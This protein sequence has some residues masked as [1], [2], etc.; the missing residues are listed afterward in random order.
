MPVVLFNDSLCPAGYYCPRGTSFAYE[1]P[2]PPGTFSNISGLSSVEG[3]TPCLPGNYCGESGLIEPSGSCFAGYFCVAGSDTP[4]PQESQCPAG[5][6]CPIGTHTPVPCPTGTFSADTLN[7]AEEDCML[8]G[9]GH[10]CTREGAINATNMPCSDGYVCVG[11]AFTPTPIDNVT[12]YA[13]PAGHFCTNASFL[14]QKCP[15]GSYQ[16]DVGKAQCLTCPIGTICYTS[17]LVMYELCPEGYYCPDM[18]MINGIPCP[19]GTFSNITGNTNISDCISCPVG[20]Y[21]NSLSLTKP[22]GFCEAGYLCVSS[23]TSPSPQDGLNEPCPPGFY[24]Q[25]GATF[26]E[27]CPTG[28]MAPYIDFSLNGIDLAQALLQWFANSSYFVISPAVGLGSVEDCLP[29]IGGFYCQLLNSTL[30]TGPCQAGYY[31]PHNASVAQG[32]PDMYQCPLG[33]YCPMASSAPIECPPGTYANTTMTITCSECPVGHF[34][35]VGAVIPTVCPPRYYCPAGSSEPLFCP[36]GTYTLNT[37]YGLISED[38]CV[39]C[40][41][42][43]FCLAG[44]IVGVCSAGYICYQGSGD[45]TPDGS[46]PTVGEPCPEGFYCIQGASS[47]TACSEGL[48]NV[49]PGGRSPDDC[50]VCPPGRVCRNGSRLAEMCP[51]GFFC[52]NGT[53]ISC[54]PGTYSLELN[55]E[56]VSFC[57]PCEPGFLCPDEATAA[58]DQ[59]PCPVGHYCDRGSSYPTACPPGTHRNET[60]GMNVTDCIICPAG[61]YCSENGTVHGVPCDISESCPEG[62]IDPIPCQPGFYC[63]VPEI[64]LPCPPGYYCPEGSSTFIECPPDHYCEQPACERAF[65]EQA[66]ADRPSICP[67]GYREILNLGENFTRDSLNATCEECPPGTYINASSLTEERI[68]LP[69]PPGYYCIGGSTFGD[70]GTSPMLFAFICPLGHY[71]PTGSEEPVACPV[72]TYNAYEGQSSLSDCT[73]CAMNE[74]N[75]MTGQ[76]GCL[77]CPS[78]STTFGNGSTSCDCIGSNRVFQV[79]N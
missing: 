55:A 52:M 12:G 58:Y 57:L 25:E 39:P 40:I 30:P 66:G 16:P 76:Q 27:P 6:F 67:L 21:C 77:L 79:H 42:S 8:C 4:T 10:Y 78:R 24:C 49:L 15:P 72:G 13:C 20:M 73:P 71:C 32:D 37:T 41:Q 28:T 60:T 68:C 3:C 23:A 65:T 22:S 48:F 11:G 34:C 35:S 1:Y 74:Y 44:E 46:N 36:N 33:N 7:V 61:F 56:D 19:L 63:P 51:R 62:A 69:C 14:E 29:C 70:P 31:C 50:T 17:S 43:H 9:P 45:P 38:Q 53:A 64:R 5:H 47:P 75:N 54:P 18:G 26:P 2:C 59:N